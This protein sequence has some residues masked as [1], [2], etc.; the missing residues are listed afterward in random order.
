MTI[1]FAGC[2]IGGWWRDLCDFLIGPGRH[3]RHT[4]AA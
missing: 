4:A 3:M 1:H 2:G